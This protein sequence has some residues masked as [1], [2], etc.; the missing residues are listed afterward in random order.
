VLTLITITGIIPENVLEIGSSNGYRLSEIHKKYA[1]HV[2][3]V[4]PSQSAI[5]DGKAQFTDV[6]FLRGTASHIPIADDFQFDLVIVHFV[7]H[8]IDRSMLLRSVAEIDRM[9]KSDGHIIIGDFHPLYPQRV[10][11]HH[12]PE[13]NVWTYK[14][15]YADIFLASNMYQVIASFDFDHNT[16]EIRTSIPFSNRGHVVMI[17]KIPELS[18]VTTSLSI[19]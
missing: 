13:S 14:Q 19:P 16:Q 1:C 2:T 11:Y 6:T 3:A 18:Y 12:L 10:A 17:Q 15:S 8:W 4:E 5:E 9:L 7:F